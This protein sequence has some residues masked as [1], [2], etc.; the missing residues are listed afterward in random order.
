MSTL[1]TTKN[2]D[3]V[4]DGGREQPVILVVEDD[5]PMRQMIAAV[6]ESLDAIV[7]LSKDVRQAMEIIETREVAVVLTD[8]RMPHADGIDILKFS[9][10]RNPLTQVVLITGHATVE[11]AVMALKNGAFDY[12]RKP[13]EP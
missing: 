6:L 4:A 5:E 8:L 13:F 12:L 2:H 10:M 9:R 11:S 7:L 3:P 1:A